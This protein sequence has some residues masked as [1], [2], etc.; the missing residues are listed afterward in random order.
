M[1]AQMARDIALVDQA[2]DQLRD[3]AAYGGHL[4]AVLAS[5]PMRKKQKRGKVSDG[6]L[7]DRV[8][9]ILKAAPGPVMKKAIVADAGARELD[10]MLT[11]KELIA[12]GRILK[13]GVRAGTK[14]AI[15][16][17]GGK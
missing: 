8:L 15:A 6:S 16:K 1:R 9:G 14:Y 5:K 4:G 11:V 2:I 13:T 7:A 12:D 10:V 17:G 3:V